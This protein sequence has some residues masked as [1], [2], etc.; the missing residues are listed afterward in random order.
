MTKSGHFGQNDQLQ[1]Q[2]TK[3]FS[4]Y[5]LKSLKNDSAHTWVRRVLRGD[6]ASLPVDWARSYEVAA[7]DLG[8]SSDLPRLSHLTKL[9][10]FDQVQSTLTSS[11]QT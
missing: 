8:R 7:R 1:V 4:T 9:V 5:A 3:L 10:R 2:S 11:D 6:H